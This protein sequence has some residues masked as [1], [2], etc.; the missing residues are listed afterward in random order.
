MRNNLLVLCLIFVRN[1]CGICETLAKNSQGIVIKCVHV[2]CAAGP[3]TYREYQ[4]L[5][6]NRFNYCE[7]L[8]D[9]KEEAALKKEVG[10]S[11]ALYQF[12]QKNSNWALSC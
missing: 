10:R 11:G 4:S 8:L 6:G 5:N 3:R 1:E 12:L 2:V 9:C 7:Y